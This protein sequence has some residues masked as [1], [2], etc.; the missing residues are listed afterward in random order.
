MSGAFKS[1]KG[2][3][4]LDSGQ[5]IGSFFHKTV[6]LICHHDPQGAFGLVVNRPSESNVGEMLIADLPDNLKEHKLF[7]GGPV[8]PTALSY[9]HYDSF[10]PDANVLPNVSLGHSLETLLEVGESFSGSKKVKLF[11]GYAGWSAGQL[12]EE[13]ERKAWLTHAASIDLIFHADS[14]KIYQN[15][16]AEKGWEYRLLAQQPDDLS[17]N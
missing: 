4:L 11:A 5:L 3:F 12:E 15:I 14:Q 17:W 10:V 16:L 9:L 13:M 6:V 1:L 8:Q 2:Q 7:I